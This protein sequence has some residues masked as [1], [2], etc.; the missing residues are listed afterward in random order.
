MGKTAE[1]VTDMKLSALNTFKA[2]EF[3]IATVW[4]YLEKTQRNV[5]ER[6][7]SFA[8]E[9]AGKVQDAAANMSKCA[10]NKGLG[11]TMIDIIT[12]DF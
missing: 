6:L 7:D 10:D 2:H 3:C 5:A 1:H 9:I 8:Y 4:R 12:Q 11:N